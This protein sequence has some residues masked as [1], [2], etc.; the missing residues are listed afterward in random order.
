MVDN[1]PEVFKKLVLIL[2]LSGVISVTLAQTD[3]LGELFTDEYTISSE[4]EGLLKLSIEN[5]SF[6]KNN[7]SDGDIFDG[8]SLPGFRF[9]PRVIFYPSSFV[10]LEAGASLL[11][12]WGADRYP[13]YA[14]QDIAE[15]KADDYQSGFHI[16]P[17]FRAQIQPI[18]Q[19]QVVL[20]T[21]YGGSNHRLIEPLYNPELNLT[22]DPESGAQ[23]LYHSRVAAVDL[24]VNWESF[25][26]RNDTHN[27]AFTTGASL[28][29]N[30][31]KPHSFFYMGIPVQA[32]MIHRGGEVD[33]VE[34]DIVS[35]A[36]GAAGLRFQL[37]FNQKLLKNITCDLMGAG[38]ESI[39]GDENLPFSRG[40]ALYSNLSADIGNLKLK[41]AWWSSEDFVNILGN[42]VFGN[43]SL[44]IS[45]RT[46]ARTD[47]FNFGLAY[48]QYFGRGFTLGADA[49]LFYNP[50]LVAYESQP[51][52]ARISRS[53]NFSMGIY[54]RINPSIT[55]KKIFFN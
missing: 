6:F 34:G 36:N 24:W 42:P 46:F 40:W 18:R 32:L 20:G 35:M 54:L 15:W 8:Y 43:L 45:G 41:A 33:S 55:L 3:T 7:E 28:C 16:L 37:N 31:T 12:Y 27:E 10:K 2:G 21:I 23:F 9:M 26:F 51:E 53:S 4:N 29:L 5:L 48:E 22:A 49:E 1:V 30:L 25:T 13:C 38:Y 44:T 39:Q 11:R 14:Y 17:F 52:P 50:R 47:V 19:I